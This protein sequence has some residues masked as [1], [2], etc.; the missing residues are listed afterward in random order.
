MQSIHGS[1]SISTIGQVTRVLGRGPWNEEFVLSFIDE[2]RKHIE[3]RAGDI[4]FD[5]VI[6]EGES[7]FIPEA[8]TT[9]SAAMAVAFAS[10]LQCSAIVLGRSV[11]AQSAQHQFE[12]MLNGANIPHAFF[13]TEAQAKTWLASKGMAV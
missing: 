13:D 5:I 3:N 9:L 10:G 1:F 12:R 6:A 11:V 8:E 4:W 2:Y 7:L